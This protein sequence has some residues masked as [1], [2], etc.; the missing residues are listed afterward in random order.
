MNYPPPHGYGYGHQAPPPKSGSNVLVIVLVV[1]VVSLVLGG[2]GCLLC[3]GL[4]ATVADDA[5]SAVEGGASPVSSARAPLVRSPLAVQLEG[6]LKGTKV[7]VAQVTCPETP[8]KGTFTCE[9]TTTSG[10]RA[11]VEVK[12]GASGLAYEVPGVAFLDGAKLATQFQAI[13]ASLNRPR[14]R[15]SCFTGTLM[16]KVGQDFACAVTEGQSPAGNVTVSVEDKNGAVHMTYEAPAPGAVAV[17]PRTVDFV[18]PPGQKPGGA[19]R[20]GCVCGDTILGTACGV[21]GSFT[22]VVETPTGCRFTCN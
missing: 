14:A 9:L 13:A 19:V 7:P 11:D 18:C 5:A 22:D 1:L 3:V 4:A 8:P 17:K 16:K 21:A 2:G 6:A 10:D 15:A 20:G 12:A